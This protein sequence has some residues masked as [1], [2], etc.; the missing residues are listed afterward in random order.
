MLL[1]L[2]D[3][4]PSLQE[5]LSQCH[6]FVKYLAQDDGFCTP[7]KV[8]CVS[9]RALLVWMTCL[10]YD[11]IYGS[12]GDISQPAAEAIGWD[13]CLERF[14]RVLSQTISCDGTVSWPSGI[15]VPHR[16]PIVPFAN[17]LSMLPRQCPSSGL[18]Q[19]FSPFSTW[20]VCGQ[21]ISIFSRRGPWWTSTDSS[22]ALVC[23]VDN[24]IVDLR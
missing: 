15:K 10:L 6:S 16:G 12:S 23:L 5:Q 20:A 24:K 14:R 21:D 8:M 22:A 17:H 9:E 3:S 11:N 1:L 18:S 2:I 13:R 4:H 19:F 7:Q